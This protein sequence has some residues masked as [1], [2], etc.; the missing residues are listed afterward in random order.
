MIAA[1]IGEKVFPMT[2]E[3]NRITISITMPIFLNITHRQPHSIWL[4]VPR[5]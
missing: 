2:T 5:Q 1:L 3:I 4:P